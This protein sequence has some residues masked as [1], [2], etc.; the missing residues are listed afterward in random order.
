MNALFYLRIIDFDSCE[1]N[2][3]M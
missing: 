1:V 3:E 2:K